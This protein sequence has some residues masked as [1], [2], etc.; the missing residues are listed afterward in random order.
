MFKNTY[1]LCECK[2]EPIMLLQSPNIYKKISIPVIEFFFFFQ[3]FS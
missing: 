2:I 3:V 1:Y